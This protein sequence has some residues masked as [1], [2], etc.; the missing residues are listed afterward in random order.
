MAAELK[1][2]ISFIDKSF[3]DSQIR[4]YQLAMQLDLYGLD[5][6]VFNPDKNKFIA[7]ESYK[8][9]D[10]TKTEELSLMFDKIL[11]HRQW[12]A[13]PFD[14]VFLLYQNRYNTLIP[15]PLF[16]PKEKSLY[17]GFNQPFQENSRI[18]YEELKNTGAVNIFYI[19]NPVVEKVKDFWPNAKINHITGAFIE[20]LTLNYKNKLSGNEMF[21]NVRNGSFDL[22]FFKNNKLFYTNSFAYRTKEDFIYFL[23]SAIEHLS[24]NPEDVNLI[25]SGKTD[26]GSP[27]YEMIYQY[28]KYNTFIKRNDNFLYSYLM[29]N[30]AHHYFYVLFNVF[31]CEL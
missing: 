4:T 17:L 31:Q 21:I 28:I 7:L 18:V 5:F 1:P 2:H 12:F 19:P 11:N 29:D 15:S 22:V 13:F 3:K 14:K 25:I 6:V 20:S 8:F 9:D 23:L 24:L 30:F 26:K 16:D 10:G 27:E